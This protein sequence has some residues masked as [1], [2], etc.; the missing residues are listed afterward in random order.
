MK[1]TTFVART[2]LKSLILGFV[3]S[4]GLIPNPVMSADTIDPEA[5]KI[6]KSMSSYLAQT[7]AFNVNADIALD[8]VTDNGEK[9]QLNSFAKVILQ[10]QNQ[11]YIERKGQLAD[12]EFIFDGKTLTLHGKKRNVYAQIAVSGTV[13]DA[14]RAY[15][16]ETGI[17]A[18][19]ADLLFANPYTILSTGVKSS[20]YLG[21]A[22]VNGIECHHLAFREAQVDWQIWIQV[23]DQPLPMKYIIT[24]KWQ[25]VAP[26]YE[27]RFRDWA[28]N[29]QID[30]KQ[31]T[32]V[33]P[34]GATKLEALSVSE[35]DE[36]ISIEE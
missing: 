27:I 7:K 4:L 32:F 5:D 29:P 36:F 6:L 3:L 22:Y 20:T 15:E 12:A 19:G 10:R 14:I 31:F 11:F 34:S 1:K 35:I 2:G 24:S 30:N 33:A 18:P 8:V 28:I 13:D 23:G 9:L 26:Q 17:P 25:A 21:T 16:A